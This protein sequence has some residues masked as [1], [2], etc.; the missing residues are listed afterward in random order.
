MTLRPSDFWSQ[1]PEK[2]QINIETKCQIWEEFYPL[3]VPHL[4]SPNPN[5]NKGFYL[6][7][8]HTEVKIGNQL[9][10]TGKAI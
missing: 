3:P 4:Q 1:T 2:K 7:N 5:F 8:R 6:L 10:K 9:A